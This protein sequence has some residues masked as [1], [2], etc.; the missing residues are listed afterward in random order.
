MPCDIFLG[1]AIFL[2]NISF[3]GILLDALFDAA[4]KD[5]RVVVDLLNQGI[6]NGAVRPL[7]RKV[8]DKDE[9]EAAYRFMASGKHMSKIILK[10]S[11]TYV[12]CLF[13]TMIT[14]ENKIFLPF[15]FFA[16]LQIRDEESEK[17]TMPVPVK[18][19]AI[20]RAICHPTKAYVIT[21]KES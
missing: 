7:A 8:F 6:K 17:V 18:V 1:M 21:G 14:F 13:F 9:V 10:V 15:F 11:N 20:P 16:C 5:K 19:K 12:K 2:K 4:N 3:H